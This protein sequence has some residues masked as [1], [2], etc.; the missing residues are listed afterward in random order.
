MALTVKA[1]RAAILRNIKSGKSAFIPLLREMA[2]RV[3]GKVTQPI[4]AT[5][6]AKVTEL[7][8]LTDDEL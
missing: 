5:V 4:D 3:E 7:S 1:V 6:D 2:D 8:Q